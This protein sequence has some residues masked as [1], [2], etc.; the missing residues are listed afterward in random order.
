MEVLKNEQLRE[1]LET[2]CNLVD[3]DEFEEALKVVREE[4]EHWGGSIYLLAFEHQV[5]QLRDFSSGDE[6]ME[7]QRLDILDSLPGLAEK[8]AEK[9]GITFRDLPHRETPTPDE[10]E[11]TRRWLLSQYLQHA[12][13]FLV[14][15]EYAS[16]LTE[17]RRMY[18]LDPANTLAKDL[19]TRLGARLAVTPGATPEQIGHTPTP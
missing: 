6:S 8:A 9:P 12:Y 2:A 13:H 11:A 1:R 3:E 14:Q 7:M 19:E 5:E 4:L 18:I 15:K 16:A 10:Q 17:V